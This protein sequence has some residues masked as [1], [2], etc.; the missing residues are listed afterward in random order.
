MSN[1]FGSSIS[2]NKCNDI[3]NRLYFIQELL[4][5][6]KL[7][8]IIDDNCADTEALISHNDHKN[9][10]DCH[11]IKCILKKKILDFKSIITQIGG[12]LIYIKSGTTGHTFKGMTN[13]ANEE[14]SIN[15]AV[16]VVAYPKREG[17]GGIYDI[18]RPEN[19][20]LLM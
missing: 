16:K 19:V 13:P 12:K 18:R 11:D 17:Y 6:K 3:N 15:F 10:C 4:D 20:E 7:N 8:P 2:L 9:N 14:R 1:L 5:G